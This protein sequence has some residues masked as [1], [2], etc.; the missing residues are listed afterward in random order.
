M[1]TKRQIKQ[2]HL[3]IAQKIIAYV[4]DELGWEIDSLEIDRDR[5]TPDPGEKWKDAEVEWYLNL[6]CAPKKGDDPLAREKQRH[7]NE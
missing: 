1:R 7:S 4:Q 3:A 6:R 2:S 5:T